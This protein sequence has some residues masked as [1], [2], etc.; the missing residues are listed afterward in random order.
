MEDLCDKWSE[1]DIG[2]DE[3]GKVL[4]LGEDEL[5]S[6]SVDLSRG[7]LGKLLR[8][9]PFNRNAFKS[10]MAG[11]RRPKGK[12]EISDYDGGGFCFKFEL[13]VDKK[14]SGS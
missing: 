2:E 10:V 13:E 6:T 12:L 1:L 4:I 14:E 3:E 11:I 5:E 7:L 8:R 9:K